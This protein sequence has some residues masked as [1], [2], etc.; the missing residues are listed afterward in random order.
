MLYNFT[1][2]RK[3][4]FTMT[5]I[6]VVVVIFAVLAAF[7]LPGFE[8]T[9]NKSRERTAI[10]SLSAINAAN[11][12]YMAK[13][14]RYYQGNLGNVGQINNALIIGIKDQ[15]M[16]YSYASSGNTTYTASVAWAG[17]GA[18]TARVDERSLSLADNPCCSAGACPTLPA[19]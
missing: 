16:N 15:D 11:E 9:I 19:C 13:Y 14:S 8:K 6:M 3:N 17:G 10:M 2:R 5:E 1:N 18:F 4:A 7:A 12:I